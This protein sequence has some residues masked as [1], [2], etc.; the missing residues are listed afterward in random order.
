MKIVKKMIQSGDKG[1]IK[2]S[3]LLGWIH[4]DELK[5]EAF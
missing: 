2:S 4:T 3:D 5:L 1:L